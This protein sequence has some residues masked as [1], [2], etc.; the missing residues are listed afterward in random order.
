[1][2]IQISRLLIYFKGGLRSGTIKSSLVSPIGRC[3]TG[4]L[5]SVHIHETTQVDLP[6]VLLKQVSNKTKAAHLADPLGWSHECGHWPAYLP[7]GYLVEGM[8]SR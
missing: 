1:M 5:A 8:V 2:D 7:Q 3:E 6:D 4:M